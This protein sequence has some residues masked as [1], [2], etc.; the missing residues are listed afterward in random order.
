MNALQ[1]FSNN[2]FGQIRTVFMD[3]EPWMVGKD[4]A[5]ALG[6]KEPTKAAREKVDAADR[7]VSKIDTPSG[8][9]EMTI[10][11][12]S[13]LYSLVL[14]SKLPGARKFRRWVTSEVLPSIRKTGGYNLPK[15]F[16]SALRALADTEEQ[17]LALLAE[18]ERQRQAIADFEPIRNYVDTILSYEGAMAVSQIAADYHISAIK[19]N[20]ILHEAGLQYRVNGQWILY[21]QHAG[22]GYTESETI[23]INHR[24]GSV[25][26]RLFTRWTQKGRLLIHDIW[27][28]QGIQ[29][30]MDKEDEKHGHEA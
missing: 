5:R 14:S 10:I 12:E 1:V 27:A 15:D 8:I 2:E 24:D 13:G 18:N 20:R 29:A 9:Q 17:R 4:V 3:G 19:L 7:G 25:T 22:K 21:Q 11:N 30:A 16:P 28:R 23:T 6:Y 26:T